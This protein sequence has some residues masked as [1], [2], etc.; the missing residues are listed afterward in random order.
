MIET[1]IIIILLQLTVYLFQLFLLTK[2]FKNNPAIDTTSNLGI[3][4][5]VAARDEEQNIKTVIKYLKNQQYPNELF[6]VILVDDN[7]SDSTFS[8]VQNEIMELNNFFVYKNEEKTLPGKR[9]ALQYGI[10]KS[11]FNFIL[12]T[13]ADCQPQTNWIN[14]FSSKFNQGNDFL[15]GI[16][17]FL[18]S[19]G[20]ANLFSRYENFKNNLLSFFLIEIGFPYTAAARSFGFSKENFYKLNG[21]KNTTDTLS[22]DDDLLL[23]EAVKNKFK[24]SSVIEKDSM[25]FSETKRTLKEYFIQRSRHTQSSHVY[26]L[27]HKIILSFWYFLNIISDFSIWLSFVNPL[28]MLIFL[29]KFLFAIIYIIVFDSKFG[30]SFLWREFFIG[31]L[32]YS[33]LL[34]IHFINSIFQKPKWK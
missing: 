25:V 17:P 21:Y 32:T 19:S 3:S 13:D 4:I 6:E 5:I 27:S 11:K 12:I 8:T 20:L 10:S 7:S 28:F 1:I 16:A 23:R 29:A 34:I 9:G 33:Y 31:E 22:G 15:I 24:I 30:Y 26:L 2:I 18:K 14:S